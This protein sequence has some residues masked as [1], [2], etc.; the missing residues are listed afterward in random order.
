MNVTCLVDTG[1][2]ALERYIYD[3]YGT[4]TVLDAD[5]SADADNVSDYMNNILFAGYC[6]DWETG[7]YH[8][9]LRPY[10]APLGRWLVRDPLGYFDGMSLYEYCH[11][12]TNWERDPFGNATGRVNKLKEMLGGVWAV[13]PLDAYSAAKGDIANFGH[14]MGREFA[15]KHPENPAGVRNAARHMAWQAKLTQKFG[16]RKAKQIG[17]L[18]ELGDATSPDPGVR[19]DTEIDQH[20]NVIGREIGERAKTDD[21]IRKEIEKALDEGRAIVSPNDPRLKNKAAVCADVSGSESNEDSSGPSSEDDTDTDDVPDTSSTGSEGTE[22]DTD[23][24]PTPNSDTSA[25]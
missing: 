6:Y 12:R 23:M 7:L 18:H 11:S 22:T 9:R 21:D 2:D 1:G 24:S 8:V 17:N 3:A 20:N 4:P 16:A 25:P 19:A 15:D 10:H 13:G 14:R 5:W